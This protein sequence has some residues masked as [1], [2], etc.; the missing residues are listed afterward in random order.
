MGIYNYLFGLDHFVSDDKTIFKVNDKVI[1]FS[2]SDSKEYTDGV[3]VMCYKNSILVRF[4]FTKNPVYYREKYVYRN[5]EFNK[6]IKLKKKK[7]KKSIKIT[8]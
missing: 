5:K 1:V 8:I 4:A 6:M 7:D 3:I 2:K